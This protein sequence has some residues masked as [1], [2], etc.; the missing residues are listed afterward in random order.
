MLE[1]AAHDDAARR[2]KVPTRP[3]EPHESGGRQREGDARTGSCKLAS[4]RSRL[5]ALS[6]AIASLGLRSA[7][8]APFLPHRS[9]FASDSAD[10]ELQISARPR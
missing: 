3:S 5:A 10:A 2:R 7:A 4:P 9:V 6:L 8:A 1:I